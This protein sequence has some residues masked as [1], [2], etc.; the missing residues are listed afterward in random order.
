VSALTL[1]GDMRDH[2]PPASAEELAVFE[3][4]VLAGV[5][6]AQPMVQALLS[7]HAPGTSSCLIRRPR[8]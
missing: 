3:T 2:R 1:I 6:S 8:F 4:D 7:T 5:D